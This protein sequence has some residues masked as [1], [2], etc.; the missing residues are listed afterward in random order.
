MQRKITEHEKTLIQ[1]LIKKSGET[2]DIP[3]LVTELKDGGMGSIQFS[4]GSYSRDIV[5]M[6]Y[7]DIDNMPVVVTLTENQLNQLFEL[8]IWKINFSPLKQ[9]PTPQMLELI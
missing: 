3:E 2:Y 9:F 8:D 6:K 5:Q 7:I 1:F 4:S